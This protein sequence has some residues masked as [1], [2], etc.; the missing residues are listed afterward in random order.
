M[1]YRLTLELNPPRSAQAMAA[2]ARRFLG[3]QGR[4]VEVE[5]P[6]PPTRL[7][8]SFEVDGALKPK[9]RPR[10][11]R[12]RVYTPRATVD[13]EQAVAQA[14]TRSAPH[15]TPNPEHLYEVRV[16]TAHTTRHAR[17]VDNLSK[18]VLD[19]LNGLAWTDDSQVVAL[20]VRKGLDPDRA[21]TRV[22]ILHITP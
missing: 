5:G 18:T 19:A 17:D 15:H 11:T 7:V 21:W 20:S 22:Q 1:R 9:E 16:V 10:F 14:F 3:K 13:S 12:G 8:A 2:W 6:I 4:V